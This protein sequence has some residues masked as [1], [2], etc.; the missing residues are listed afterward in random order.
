MGETPAN[1]LM[2]H[3]GITDAKIQPAKLGRNLESITG[4]GSL[5]LEKLIVKAL[6]KRLGIRFDE[7]NEF[8]FEEAVKVARN[9]FAGG[10]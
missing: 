2:F 9:S 8:N 3:A 1:A 10:A 5:V 6:D 4:K 7:G